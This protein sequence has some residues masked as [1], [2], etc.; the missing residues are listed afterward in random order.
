VVEYDKVID[1]QLER[2]GITMTTGFS[3]I[4]K[5]AVKVLNYSNT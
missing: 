4:F 1:K 3:R 2:A 5:D